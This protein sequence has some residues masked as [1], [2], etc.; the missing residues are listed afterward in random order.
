MAVVAAVLH[1]FRRV[2]VHIGEA[3]LI[4]RKRSHGC[5][6]SSPAGETRRYE[7]NVIDLLLDNAERIW[8]GE[9]TL[10]NQIV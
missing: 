7:D 1:P 8:R 5:N 4:G 9:Q 6:A 2:A 3:E 10:R